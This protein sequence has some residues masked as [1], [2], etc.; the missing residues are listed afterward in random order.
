MGVKMNM[1]VRVKLKAPNAP[2]DPKMSASS[3]RLNRP[4]ACALAPPVQPP[5]PSSPAPPRT[6]PCPR[7]G[8]PTAA[9]TRCST[10][11]TSPHRRRGLQAGVRRARRATPARALRPFAP[12]HSQARPAARAT[13]P[14]PAPRARMC[15]A[16]PATHCSA[17]A[18]ASLRPPA[19]RCSRHAHRHAPCCARALPPAPRAPGTAR[20]LRREPRVEPRDLRV[21][22]R[23]VLVLVGPPAGRSTGSA[24]L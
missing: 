15:P 13:P 24:V 18:G 10:P 21:L 4:R 16:R 23:L 19:P 9:R 11:R 12:R 7:R 8:L 3:S 2:S 1:H 22:G 14:R 5:L 17:P 6:C 20:R